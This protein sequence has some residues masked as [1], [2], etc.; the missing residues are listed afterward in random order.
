M[1]VIKPFWWQKLKE[2][3]P[4]LKNVKIP[5]KVNEKF[6]EFYGILLGDGCV[7]SNLKGFN[8]SGDKFLDYF[9]YKNYLKEL[10]FDLFGAHPSIYVL[11]TERSIKCVFTA[12]K[13]LNTLLIWAFL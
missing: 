7:F 5:K 9:Y 1:K 10:I 2:G 8:I 11:D 4:K 6:S 3:R 12:Q 13:L